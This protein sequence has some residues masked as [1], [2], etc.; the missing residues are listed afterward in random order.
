MDDIPETLDAESLANDCD[1]IWA[2]NAQQNTVCD[3]FA[4]GFLVGKM[5]RFEKIA[6]EPFASQASRL[7]AMAQ[8]KLAQSTA[9]SICFG[10][11]RL[12]Q[13]YELGRV[14]DSDEL[15]RLNNP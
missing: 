6:A 5:M 13:A 14:F 3:A 2:Q 7:T 1:K 10:I 8:A 11:L 9:R 12:D 4:L 15:G